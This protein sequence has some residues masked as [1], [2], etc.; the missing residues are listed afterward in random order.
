MLEVAEIHLVPFAG[1][2][3]EKE[4]KSTFLALFTN[5]NGDY[6]T[7]RFYRTL[8]SRLRQGGTSNGIESL[9]AFKRTPLWLLQHQNYKFSRTTSRYS[10]TRFYCG[11]DLS[12]IDCTNVTLRSAS[13]HR[14]S[15]IILRPQFIM[16]WWDCTGNKNSSIIDEMMN[17]R[18]I[19]DP[20]R[21]HRATF[22]D[23]WVFT[24][25]VVLCQA[26]V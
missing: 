24:N 16:M 8:V 9:L 23:S 12:E 3:T 6:K 2:H 15:F 18:S 26:D 14:R 10:S 17:Y 19:V 4:V 1:Y 21:N 13:C 5:L 25:G 22:Q 20:F 11:R 7:K